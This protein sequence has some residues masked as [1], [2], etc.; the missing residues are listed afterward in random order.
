MSLPHACHEL[1][2]PHSI[3]GRPRDTAYGAFDELLIVTS[4]PT[5]RGLLPVHA[6]TRPR[7]SKNEVVTKV[8]TKV[9]AKVRMT[10]IRSCGMILLLTLEVNLIENDF[11][12]RLD[13]DA[14]H[15]RCKGYLR[16]FSQGYEIE[17]EIQ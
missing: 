16:T 1:K 12:N 10:C 11:Q 15:I 7:P 6:G 5:D 14:C 2:V 17:N 3:R 4:M 13:R 8:V 9:V